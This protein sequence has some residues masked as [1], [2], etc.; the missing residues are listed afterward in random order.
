MTETDEDRL[1]RIETQTEAQWTMLDGQTFPAGEAQKS[2]VRFV[3]T[4]ARD[5]IRFRHAVT[6]MGDEPSIEL[7][8]TDEQ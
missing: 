4:L 6:E 1:N 5:G 3:F 2:D 8:G 7:K